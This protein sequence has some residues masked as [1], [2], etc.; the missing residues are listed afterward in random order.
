LSHRIRKRLCL[1]VLCGSLAIAVASPPVIGVARS[2]GSF[3]INHASVP[4]SATILEGAFVET[5]NSPSNL[6]LKSGE[7]V[8]LASRSSATIH[9]DHLFLDR[10][11]A[12]LN[13]SSLYQIETA[14]LHIT[15]SGSDARIRVLVGPTDRVNI[16]AVGGNAEVHNTQGMLVARIFTGT[17]LQIQPA[18]P[19]SVRLT[20]TLRAMGG[21]YFLTD[22]TNKVTVELRGSNLANLVGKR[23]QVTGSVESGATPAAGASQVVTVA[24]ATAVSAAGAGGGAAAGAT[25]AHGLSTATIAV[26]GG[27]AATAGTVGG[28]YAAGVIGGSTAPVSQ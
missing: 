17:A 22:E 25:V 18:N 6:V 14:N 24:Q 4:G 11:T 8:L 27:A 15:A 20:G 10:G 2:R 19:S 9:Q 21:K 3:L 28:L 26:I 7:R 1:A 23:V 13:G 5:T 12:E 16:E